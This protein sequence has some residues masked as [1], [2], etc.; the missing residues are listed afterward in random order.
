MLILVLFCTEWTITIPNGDDDQSDQ[1]YILP[2]T[3]FVIL[4]LG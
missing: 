2:N 3:G 4:D 1:M